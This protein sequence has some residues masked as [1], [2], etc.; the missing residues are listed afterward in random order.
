MARQRSEFAIVPVQQVG[1]DVK[2]AFGLA[3]YNSLGD[4]EQFEGVFENGDTLYYRP[5]LQK[6]HSRD[7]DAS[8]LITDKLQQEI[9]RQKISPDKIPSPY[10]RALGLK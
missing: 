4:I 7:S 2:E 10:H 9:G 6:W 3:V 1:K 8:F 5:A